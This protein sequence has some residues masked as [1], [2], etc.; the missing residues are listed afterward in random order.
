MYEDRQIVLRL[1][2]M[3]KQAQPSPSADLLGEK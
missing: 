3:R 2:I 1:Q